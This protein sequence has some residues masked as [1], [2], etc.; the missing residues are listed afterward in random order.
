MVVPLI[1]PEPDQLKAITINNGALKTKNST[2]DLMLS[3]Q[4][5]IEMMISNDPSF[6][7]D[8]PVWETYV[9]AKEWEVQ[10][11]LVGPGFGDGEK[12]VY[13]K[14]RSISEVSDIF[15]ATITLDTSPPIVGAVPIMVNS[16]ALKTDTQQVVLLLDAIGADQVEIF[17]EVDLLF[18]SGGTIVPYQTTINWTLSEGNGIKTVYVTFMDNIGNKSSF[19]SGSIT[20]IGQTASI[21]VVLAPTSGIVTSPFISIQ[22]TGDPGAN[23]QVNITKEST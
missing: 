14:F 2:I 10:D 13:V 11:A 15:S 6:T 1:V 21:P 12:T 9:S 4:G 20:L 17:N 23:V 19:F 3:A 18:I 7:T 5:A 8:F 16:G 22:G